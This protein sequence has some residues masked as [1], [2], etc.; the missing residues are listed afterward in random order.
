MLH[1]IKVQLLINDREHNILNHLMTRF[2]EACNYISEI[3]FKTK[4]HRNKIKLSKECYNDVRRI[5]SLP[6]QM[7]VRAIGK[8]V[9]GYKPGSSTELRFGETTPVVFDSRQIAFK[10]MDTISISTFDGRLEI[11]FRMTSCRRG[12][13]DRR[14][15]GQADLVLE[16][17]NFYLL[18]VIDLP[19]IPTI[20][21]ME[22]A[23]II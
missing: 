12:I 4:T 10:W 15:S 8:V 6:S 19:E 21:S 23:S 16:D 22:F 13:Y 5:Y 17:D 18:V 3:G 1:T 11:P 2:N 20:A 14:V 7:V 9:E